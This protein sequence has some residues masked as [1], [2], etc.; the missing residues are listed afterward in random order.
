[1]KMAKRNRRRKGLAFTPA[2]PHDRSTT[3]KWRD[4]PL[5]IPGIAGLR[6]RPWGSV[7]GV[8]GPSCDSGR[9]PEAHLECHHSPRFSVTYY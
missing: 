7:Q 2:H 9:S 4:A 5:K 3:W 8:P 1:M 6:G